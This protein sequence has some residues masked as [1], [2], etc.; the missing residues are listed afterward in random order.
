[1]ESNPAE[2]A[3]LAAFRTYLES[4]G[5]A[6]T[7]VKAYTFA[8]RSWLAGVQLDTSKRGTASVLRGALRAWS[9]WTGEPVPE[10]ALPALAPPA[11]SRAALDATTLDT[12]HRAVE[13]CDDPVARAALHVLPEAGMRLGAL[14]QARRR[15]SEPWRASPWLAGY[16]EFLEPGPWLFPGSDGKPMSPG[17]VQR[18]LRVARGARDWSTDGVRR[19][20]L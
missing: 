19:G 2:P 3:R 7:T 20:R 18:Q 4:R 9:A 6:T 8:V 5:F 15:G 14:L 16:V 13:C 1:M 12:Y 11:P 10:V 17:V